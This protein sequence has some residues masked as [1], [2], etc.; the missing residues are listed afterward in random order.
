M[1]TFGE[2]LKTVQIEITSTQKDFAK[3]L[4]I[5][6]GTLSDLIKNNTSPS[7]ETLNSLCRI[8]FSS[9]DKFIWLLTGEQISIPSQ[10]KLDE[11][12]SMLMDIFSQLSNLNKG[13]VLEKAGNLLD[14]QQTK[15]QKSA[16]SHTYKGEE[17]AT[18]TEDLA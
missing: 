6:S 8:L 10:D 5:S 3:L 2:R 11:D 17:A 18:L 4:N 7:A 14:A 1:N 12:T 9:P 16:R 13:R 15:K